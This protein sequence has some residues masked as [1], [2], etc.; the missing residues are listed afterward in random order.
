M[1]NNDKRENLVLPKGYTEKDNAFYDSESRV[2][3]G[4]IRL[5]GYYNLVN[6]T[7]PAQI[8]QVQFSTS[9]G[10]MNTV[11]KIPFHVINT[12]KLLEYIPDGFLF[13]PTSETKRLRFFQ[14]LLCLSIDKMTLDELYRVHTGYNQLPNGECIYALGNMILN[15]QESISVENVSTSMVKELRSSNNAYFPWI[16][17]F[18]LQGENHPALFISSTVSLLRPLLTV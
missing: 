8:I 7:P 16:K 13:F 18:C 2:T 3:N 1:Y 14:E 4:T 5:L 12:K 6:S 17:K 9:N 10:N 11:V 15:Q